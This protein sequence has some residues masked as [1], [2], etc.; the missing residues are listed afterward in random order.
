MAIHRIDI[1][2]HD[3]EVICQ[4]GEED[5][6]NAAAKLLNDEAQTFVKSQG[7]IGESRMLL[8]AGLMLADRMIVLQDT[9]TTLQEETKQRELELEDTKAEHIKAEA[10][11]LQ[12]EIAEKESEISD[13]RRDMQ[14]LSED[15]AKTAAEDRELRSHIERLQ[16]Q[17][18]S[19]SLPGAD[20]KLTES[21]DHK[22]AQVK[23]LTARLVAIQ[24]GG[25]SAPDPY[26]VATIEAERDEAQSEA[27][28]A[29]AELDNLKS[30][31]F[32]LREERDARSKAE[33]NARDQLEAEISQKAKE[34]R[35]LE[36]KTASMEVRL[37]ASTSAEDRLAS[38]EK[39]ISR[40][41][42]TA[43]AA[44]ADAAH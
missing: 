42:E 30:E 7:R 32:S 38:A 4:E 2:G 35:D 3:F 28:A 17:L 36:E 44:A 20:P 6:L 29:K 27:V 41:I 33:S 22:T 15:L 18:A 5:F 1:G 37:G 43:E 26:L 14:Q 10:E 11:A 19:S 12:D 39:T 40:L 34:I 23:D 9:L 13:L 8:M 31:L 25:T 24:E 21:L 16:A